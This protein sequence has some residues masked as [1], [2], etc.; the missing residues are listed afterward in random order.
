MK[1]KPYFDAVEGIKSVLNQ[2]DIL[3]EYFFVEDVRNKWNSSE[4]SKNGTIHSKV[5]IAV[6]PEAVL[7]LKSTP[8]DPSVI[9]IFTMVSNPF[10][11]IPKKYSS[12]CGFYFSVDAKEQLTWIAKTLPRIKSLGILYDQVNNQDYVSR[13]VKSGYEAGIHIQPLMVNSKDEVPESLRKNWSNLDGLLLIPDATVI[14]A[15]LVKYIIRKGL[16][17]N[18]PV[19]GY[20]RFFI[21]SGALMSFVYDYHKIG[22]QTGQ[23]VKGTLLNGSKCKSTVTQFEVVINKNIATHLGMVVNSAIKGVVIETNE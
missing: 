9:K 3:T 4:P 18:V 23:L 17:N 15:S 10:S 7:F 5:V 12:F 21:Q 20:N 13:A 11:L 19:I 16:S 8:L 1:I 2:F 6:G 22:R 14:S